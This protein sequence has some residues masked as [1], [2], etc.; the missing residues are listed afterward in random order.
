MHGSGGAPA[1]GRHADH[2]RAPVGRT[3]PARVKQLDGRGSERLLPCL[4]ARA[5]A[6]RLS[7]RPVRRPEG[8][9]VG[10]RPI[11]ARRRCGR[12]R[13][14]DPGAG[15]EPRG[16]RNR[17]RTRQ[18]S[19]LGRCGQRVPTRAA[20]QRAR[21][22]GGERGGLEL[23]WTCNG[24][25]SDG[26]VRL[27]RKLVGAGAADAARRG[28]DSARGARDPARRGDQPPGPQRHGCRRLFGG[29]PHVRGH[30]RLLLPGRA[31]PA[32]GRR[33]LRAG[34]LGRCS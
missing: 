8:G 23:A 17:G 7:G 21:D 12:C 6:R 13:A 24:R 25:G 33:V 29:G 28:R 18:P 22:L 19:R 3:Q 16:P 34:G 4:C 26:R 15:G 31:V 20:R 11:R 10:S 27:A 30:D 5:G 9:P 14:D 32:T 2:R 1:T